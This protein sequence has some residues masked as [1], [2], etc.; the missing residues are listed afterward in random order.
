[1]RRPSRWVEDAPYQI[2]LL[3]AAEEEIVPV[4][5]IPVRD[6]ERAAQGQRMVPGNAARAPGQGEELR[7]GRRRLPERELASESRVGKTQGEGEPLAALA[8]DAAD[9][10]PHVR[11]R[12]RQRR[13]GEQ[14]RRG[15]NAE[16]IGVDGQVLQLVRER[17]R[18][19]AFHLRERE[20]SG[21]RAADGSLVV[22]VRRVQ[23]AR[24]L[25]RAEVPGEFERQIRIK[26][27]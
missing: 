22:V 12:V 27:V 26:R 6:T 25:W 2:P 24:C 7:C 11:P 18:L 3:E 14:P 4:R 19:R 13:R 17:E 15:G 9:E 16:R 20:R 21:D 5:Q 1:A 23:A 10:P 8:G